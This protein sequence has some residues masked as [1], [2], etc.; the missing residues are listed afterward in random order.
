[1]PR[2]GQSM[3]EGTI[4]QWFKKE[5][6]SVN[7]GE[8]LLEVMS[9]KANFEVEAPA[10]GTLRRILAQVN[11]SV[12]VNQPIAI[13][14]QPDEPIDSLVTG[15]PNSYSISSSSSSSAVP[16]APPSPA[17]SVGHERI[18]ISPRARRIADTH[19][20]DVSS[21]Q[22]AGTGPGGRILERDVAAF[23]DRS[24]EQSKIPADSTPRRVTPLA[25]KLAD[26]LG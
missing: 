3:E 13:V 8:P 1:M 15:D 2:L 18:P 21:L 25:A 9:D 7:Q 5:G 23:L 19:G 6:D 10:N 12:P 16:A 22:G 4:L 20:I 24:P 14:G 11:D 17:K 26:D